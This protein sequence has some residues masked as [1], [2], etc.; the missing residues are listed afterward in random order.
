[1]EEFS[2]SGL[3]QLFE[4]NL[5]EINYCLRSPP[6]KRYINLIQVSGNEDAQLGLRQRRRKIEVSRRKI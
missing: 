1:M 3:V 5:Y 6:V 2:F 4:R